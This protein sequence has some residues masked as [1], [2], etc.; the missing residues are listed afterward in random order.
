MLYRYIS[1][2]LLVSIKSFPYIIQSLMMACFVG[3]GT[4]PG[5]V[6]KFLIKYDDFTLFASLV[7]SSS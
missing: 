3:P 7:F 6:T 5:P 1:Y 2:N 4:E